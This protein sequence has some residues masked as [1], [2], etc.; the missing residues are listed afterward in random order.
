[1]RIAFLTLEFVTEP[2][3]GGVGNYVN[4]VSL[5]LSK[6]GHEVEVFTRGQADDTI[7]HQGI[8]VHRVRAEVPQS[9]SRLLGRFR[10]PRTLKALKT[11]QRLRHAFQRRHKKAPFEVLQAPQYC[12]PGVFLSLMPPVPVITRVSNY[13]PLWRNAAGGRLTLDRRLFEWLEL[14]AMRYSAAVYAP[15]RCLAKIIEEDAAL[16][17]DVIA[18]PVFIETEKL[19]ES[20]YSQNI[21]NLRY[22]LFFGSFNRT[23]GLHVLAEALA[24]VMPQC[25]DMHFVFVGMGPWKLARDILPPLADRFHYLGPLP[26]SQLY[27]V[28][29]H[30]RGVV[31]PSLVD[32]LPNACLESMMLGRPV[33][34][35]RG[36]SFDE[37][38][39][40]GE[41]GFLVEPGDHLGLADAIRKMW[42]LPDDQ[43]NR[44]GKCGKKFL[45]RWSP[46]V[47]A[48]DLERYISGVLARTRKNA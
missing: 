48:A 47:A 41:S 29:Q 27:P 4:R 34:G 43:L 19:D 7:T 22:L 36:A 6:R 33:I 3:T 38:L 13:G 30:S 5:A 2:N 14:L 37:L 40:D 10:I 24:K 16:R 17:V 21:A 42:A 9:L 39:V 45:T 20:V 15:S 1:M 26:H 11:A 32:N 31:L 8:L 35:T 44:M 23:K 46:E 18:P 12:A 25:T 28:I